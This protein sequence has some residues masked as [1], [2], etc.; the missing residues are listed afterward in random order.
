MSKRILSLVMILTLI[1]T[2]AA[3]VP[4]TASAIYTAYS[5]CNN[6]KALNVRSGPGKEYPVIGSIPYG[7]QTAVDHDLGNGWSELV[8]GSVPGYAMTGLMSRMK[9]A[10]YVAPT[11]K[12]DD[13]KTAATG[14]T[15]L[16][17]LFLQ[18]RMVTPYN[19]VL[20]GARA[21]GSANVRWAPSKASTLLKAYPAGT[22]MKVIAELG[23]EWFQVE[24][25]LTGAVGFV[26]NAYVVR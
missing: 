19:I 14:N 2:L 26:N 24:D 13:N 7:E 5:A 9:P 17:N 11:N 10:P 3:A 15:P 20:K 23:A 1:M 16:N 12:Q 18:A 4:T 22:E 6:G 8:W 25:P 21:S